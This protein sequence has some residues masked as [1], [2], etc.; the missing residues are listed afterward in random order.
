M[1][2]YLLI[3]V[4]VFS[5]TLLA[6]CTS[7]EKVNPYDVLETYVDL[8]ESF[9]FVEMYDML[10]NTSKENYGTEDYIDRYEKIYKDLKIK[11]LDITITSEEFDSDEQLVNFPI[12][13]KMNSIAGP[14]QFSTEVEL[15]YNYDEENDT[16]HWLINWDPGLI[17]PELA[18]GGSIKIER[19]K[20]KRGEIVDRNNMPLAINDIAYEVGVVP[21]Y[22]VNKETEINQIANLLNMSQNTITKEIEADWVQ[23]DHFVPLKVVPKSDESTLLQLKNIPS[24]VTRETTGRMYPSSEASAHLIGYIGKITSEEL[25]ELDQEQ[26]DENDLIGKRGLEKLYETQLKGEEGVQISVIKEDEKG[27]QLASILAE[28]PVND[29]ENIQVT[30]DVNLQEQLYEKYENNIKGAAA[31]INP[32][33]G[34]ILALVSSPSFDPIKLTYGISQSSWDEL[35]NDARQPFVNRFSATYAP[36]SVIK[37]VIGMIG[38]RNG[39]IT[40]N[41]EIKIEGLTWKKDNWKDFHITRV[42]STDKPVTLGDAL[43][44]SDNIYF[45]MKAVEMGDKELTNGLKDLGFAEKLPIDL[46]FS[47]SQISNNQHLQDE[48]LRANTGYG[49][50]EI[51]VNVLHMA[52]LYSPFINDGNM[53]KPVLLMSDPKGETWKKNLINEEN[54]NK[55]NEYLRKVVTEGTATVIKNEDIKMAGK[56]GTAELKLTK[57]SKG[58]ENGWFVGY[59]IDEDDILIAMIMEEVEGMGTSSFV[60]KNVTEVIKNYKQF[61]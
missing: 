53:V 43:I 36:G 48:V 47:A 18:D 3:L 50:G 26:Y 46:P 25:K 30:I 14:I 45:A 1:K 7:N 11:D 59:P 61:K 56:T 34:E 44:R 24:I 32:K 35:M 38:L 8:W 21:S 58:H 42:S 6:S 29:G 22:F 12:D 13:V 5:T 31:A 37:P 20:P 41:E 39:S 27:D 15:Q 23:S 4:I 28:K 57:D 19:I 52:L 55:M 17:F 54:R 33:T 40:N 2:K 49:Q 10:S 60:A 16:E 9:E 51:E